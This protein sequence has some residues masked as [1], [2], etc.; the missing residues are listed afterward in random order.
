MGG[1]AFA[2]EGRFGVRGAGVLIRGRVDEGGGED[3]GRSFEE[4]LTVGDE[5]EA[6][7][8]E[9]VTKLANRGKRNRCWS[10][11][12]CVERLSSPSPGRASDGASATDTFLV[13]PRATLVS[14]RLSTPVR[15]LVPS[16]LPVSSVTRTSVA[17]I[18][19][20]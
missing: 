16:S 18:G 1:L 8:R 20:I 17:V 19:G 9:G 3:D 11:P 4:R 7:L 12:S 10:F 14:N 5:S 13:R 2:M 15:S 6:C